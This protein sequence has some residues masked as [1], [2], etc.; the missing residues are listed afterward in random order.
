MDIFHSSLII[1]PTWYQMTERH[2]NQS[3]TNLCTSP[4]HH[5]SLRP[6]SINSIDSTEDATHA[7]IRI[8]IRVRVRHLSPSPIDDQWSLLK[9][10]SWDVSATQP[11]I[12]ASVGQSSSWLPLST[13]KVA[14]C[15]LC[16][17]F[18]CCSGAWGK[19]CCPSWTWGANVAPT[20]GNIVA[21]LQG[22]NKVGS[23]CLGSM[24]SRRG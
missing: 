6:H 2:D 21:W 13:V 1:H 3:R 12:P 7:R 9:P 5:P 8:Q 10:R 19:A 14:T 23:T 16:C 20:G 15:W 22:A 18:D 24:V 11:V 17:A 4:C